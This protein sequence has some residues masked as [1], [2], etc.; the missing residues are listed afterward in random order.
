MGALRASHLLDLRQLSGGGLEPYQPI[1]GALLLNTRL[2][3]TLLR[4]ELGYQLAP[5]AELASLGLAWG[6]RLGQRFGGQL[7]VSRELRGSPVTFVSPRLFGRIQD[8]ALSLDGLL[9]DDG[10][11]AVALGLSFGAA[12]DPRTGVLRIR[13]TGMASDGAASARVFL[14]LNQN[15]RFEPGERPLEGVRFERLGAA[16]ETDAEGLTFLTGLSSYRHTKLRVERQS[17]EDP[18]WVPTREGFEIVARPGK[19]ALMEIA[20]TPT[21]EIEGTVYLRNGA[22]VGPAA[23][24]TVQLLDAAGGIVREVRSEFDGFYLFDF[25]PPAPYRVEVEPEQIRRA[26]LEPPLAH[27]V[28]VEGNGAVVSGVDFVID[29][30]P[31]PALIAAALPELL[32]PAAVEPPGPG[33]YR[34]QLASYRGPT[35]ARLGWSRLR[36]AHGEL[37]ADLGERIE[38]VSLPATV[39]YRLQAGP[40]QSER[41]AQ[42]LC[43]SFHQRGLACLVVQ[44]DGSLPAAQ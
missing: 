40:L 23:N 42:E 11:F 5:T 7:G 39:V 21:G 27:Q 17:L 8:F 32:A 35:H 26:S 41:G 34:V 30:S 14:D 31:P 10:D 16:E 2:G 43:A 44:P 1:E 24:V 12:R 19:T 4:Q 22:A 3:D 38:R 33:P 25:V 18:F 6:K 29:R 37:L 15:G 9:S 36:E 28:T 13:P 20:V